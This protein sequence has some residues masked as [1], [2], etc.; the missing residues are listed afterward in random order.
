MNSRKMRKVFHDIHCLFDGLYSLKKELNYLKK[1][2]EMA[3]P[4]K[5]FALL[6]NPIR[7]YRCN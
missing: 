6:T 2:E 3:Y 5:F 1:I 4:Q 7:K